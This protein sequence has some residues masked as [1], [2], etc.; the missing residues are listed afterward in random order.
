M[1]LPFHRA[2]NHARWHELFFSSG[3][4]EAHLATAAISLSPSEGERGGVRGPL[5]CAASIT[6]AVTRCARVFPACLF[7]PPPPTIEPR[8]SG[9]DGQRPGESGRR[10]ERMESP[11][12]RRVRFSRKGQQPGRL[13]RQK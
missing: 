7:C 13:S 10:R 4:F 5:V 12:R 9:R 3:V 2:T 8:L 1:P 6:A 11:R